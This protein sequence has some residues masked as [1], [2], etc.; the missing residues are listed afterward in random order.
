[1]P[2]IK[3][4]VLPTENFNRH[5]D[6]RRY[7]NFRDRVK[8]YAA[9]AKQAKAEQSGEKATKKWQDLFGESFGKSSSSGGGTGS[10]SAGGGRNSSH[11]GTGPGAT[12]IAAPAA[13]IP[14][15]RGRR[16]NEAHEFG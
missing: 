14:V 2:E 8:S 9:T 12:G 5:W 10:N 3:N 16:R 15:A 1:M 11:G 6:Q 13:S 7:A 4:P